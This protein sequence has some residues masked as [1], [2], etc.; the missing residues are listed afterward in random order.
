MLRSTHFGVMIATVRGHLQ[1][2]AFHYDN[3]GARQPDEGPLLKMVQSDGD[4]GTP[5]PKHQRQ[6]LVSE[7]NLVAL[8]VDD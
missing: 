6:E 2:L 7:K 1:S 3:P 8:Q 4:A 5:D